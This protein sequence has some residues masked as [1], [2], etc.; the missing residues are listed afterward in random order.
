MAVTVQSILD[1]FNTQIS[2]AS[3]DRISAAQR[4]SYVSNAVVW[5]QESLLND[6]QV[7]SYTFN[8]YDTLNFY[9]V[10]SVVPD[11][12]ETNN[13]NTKVLKPTTGQ[14]WTSSSNGTPFT[15]KSSQELKQE[16]GSSFMED[17]YSIERRDGN[18]YLVINH[19]C[20]Y[21]AL[22]ASSFSSLTGDGGTW[23]VD[24]VNSDATNLR[25][26]NTDG[27]NGTQG[28][29]AFDITVAQSANNRATILN[30]GITKEDL[31]TEQDLTSWL[32]DVKF[33]SITNITSVTFY[34]G[35]DSSNYWSVTST[36]NYDGS[37]FTADFNN[38]VKFDWLGATKTG[39]P[40][41]TAIDFFRI[42]INY[43]VGQ[44]DATSFKVD[45][46]RNVRGEQLMLSYTSWYVG[47]TSSGTPLSVFGATTDIPYFSGKY[48]QYIY[49]CGA[50]AS[51]QAFTDLRLFSEA[52]S[53]MTDATD[54]VKRL[55]NVF[56]KSITREEKSFKVKGNRL[57]HGR[58]LRNIRPN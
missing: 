1:N 12:L 15:R 5:L 48:D 27:S 34:W 9:N 29:L 26:D 20:K 53:S 45:N 6:H 17:A 13:L 28:C 49:A 8:Y 23:V 4:L 7:K 44:A 18:V 3:T 30:T 54:Q 40:V 41:V 52:Q 35:S 11:L 21:Q 25:L 50:Y 37:A 55:Q 31:T 57:W 46:L 51:A 56:P 2:D 42:D 16:I 38:T 36:T 24:A 10:T 19:E 43:G 47:T 39:T 14:P 32:L 22:V 33:P 58:R